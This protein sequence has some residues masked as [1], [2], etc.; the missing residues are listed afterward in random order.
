M[1]RGPFAYGQ[2]TAE[3]TLVMVVDLRAPPGRSRPSGAMGYTW[4]MSSTPH[5][6]AEDLLLLLLDDETGKMAASS[7]EKSVLGGALL[8][9]LALTRAVEVEK[10]A[11]V[12]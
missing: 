3:R 10:G 6:I 1:W 4:D 5:L 7:Y 12:L 11:G 2:A 9:E 8:A